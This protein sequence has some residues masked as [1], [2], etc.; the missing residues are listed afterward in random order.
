MRYTTG[1]GHRRPRV[2]AAGDAATPSSKLPFDPK[3]SE[4]GTHVSGIA[5]GDYGTLAAPGGRLPD[6]AGPLGRRAARL[7]RQLPRARDAPTRCTARSGGTAGD[8]GRGRRAAQDG[9]DVIN[10]SLGGTEIDPR[11]DA[12]VRAV[13]EA[14]GPASSWSSRPA[15]TA[16]ARHGSVGS[17]GAAT[18]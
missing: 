13:E 5:A 16:G 4:H 2:P 10:L 1:E 14:V 3:V 18:T 6:G 11:S 12:L 17:P 9:M 7:P 15:T 8:R